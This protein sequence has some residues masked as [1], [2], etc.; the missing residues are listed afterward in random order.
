[1]ESVVAGLLEGAVEA[2]GL[3]NIKSCLTDTE[4]L[5]GDIDAA[6]IDFEKKTSAGVQ[7]GL[8]KLGDATV[9]ITKMLTACPGVVADWDKLASMAS[10]FKSPMAFAYHVGQDILVNG[11]SIFHEIEAATV[12]WSAK[13]YEEFGKDVGEALAHLVLGGASQADLTLAEDPAIVPYVVDP[14]TNVKT[15][16][17]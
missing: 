4:A 6:V 17:S 16:I 2:E 12:A 5:Y 15:P 11:V 9:Q 1:M 7:D 8:A 10:I 14:D 13:N 3:E